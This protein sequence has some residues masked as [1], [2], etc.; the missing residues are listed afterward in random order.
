[1]KCE[2]CNRKKIALESRTDWGGYKTKYYCEHCDLEKDTESVAN[3][4]TCP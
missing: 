3:K 1:M 4:M 2:K